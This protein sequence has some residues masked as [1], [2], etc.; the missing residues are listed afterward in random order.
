MSFVVADEQSDE[1]ITD[2]LLQ[3]RSWTLYGLCDLELPFRQSARF[4]GAREAGR[5][6]AVVLAYS[7]PNLA[8]LIPY[9]ETAAIRAILVG[10]QNLPAAAL[11]QSRSADHSAL[12]VHYNVDSVEEMYRMILAPLDFQAATADYA[13][14]RLLTPSDSDELGS[15]HAQWEE[16]VVFEA[17]MLDVGVHVG[18]FRGGEL[19]AVSRTHCTSEPFGMAAVGG[20]FTHPEH[21]G[22]G[23]AAATTSRLVEELARRDIHD[24]QLNVKQNNPA[25]IRSYLKI[26]F[27][28]AGEF[29]EGS[30]S[31]KSP[32]DQPLPVAAPH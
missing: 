14:L 26:G 13:T 11:Y 17:S 24:V 3:D 28:I 25:A 18:A 5:L 21:R 4:V 31:L 1:E 29:L 10:A 6:R 23:L 15:L 19:V 7:L 8:I 30:L 9:G 22:H 16:Q 12:N 27:Q 20:V 32:G 2:L